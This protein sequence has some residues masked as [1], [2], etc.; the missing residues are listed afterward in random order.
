MVDA[1]DDPDELPVPRVDHRQLAQP[2]DVHVQPAHVPRRG[3]VLGIR[4]GAQIDR[5]HDLEGGGIDHLDRSRLPVRHV[6]VR[7]IVG[8]RPSEML[9]VDRGVDVGGPMG[10][11]G[12]ARR[13]TRCGDLRTEGGS[14][15]L[16]QGR[17]S[18]AADQQRPM[19][20]GC[21]RRVRDGLPQPWLGLHPT[22]RRI[23][24]NGRGDRGVG[25]ITTPDQIDLPCQGERCRV[26]DG[27]RQTGDQLR[28]A[29][30][31]VEDVDAVGGAARRQATR[32]HDPSA[33]LGHGGVS[34]SLREVPDDREGRS[35]RGGVDLRPRVRAVVAADKERR[36][37]DLRGGQIRKSDR[38]VP[39]DRALPGGGIEGLN[40]VG[41]RA[42]SAREDV[43]LAGDHG[44]GGVMDRPRERPHRGEP[45]RNGIHREHPA[46]GGPGCVEP[47]GDVDRRCRP[48]PRR[49]AG[50]VR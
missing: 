5:A 21:H 26:R 49:L 13:R 3:H 12:P 42:G 30:C 22:G 43:D 28:R 19:Q 37:P 24:F 35:V 17:R 29:R 47:A 33:E 34:Q 48:T 46:H 40:G 18:P 36:R 16:A 41:A 45:T 39:D 1:V 2:V 7:R 11:G 20:T 25:R 31:R 32:D 14:H 50:S 6:H 15:D 10:G 38:E 9:R 4:A 23:E 44:R 27:G 8:D